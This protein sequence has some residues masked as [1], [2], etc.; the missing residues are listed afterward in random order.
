MRLREF[1]GRKG[2]QRAGA[3]LHT[4]VETLE[5]SVGLIL[6]ALSHFAELSIRRLE[7]LGH[8]QAPAARFGTRG[9]QHE[10]IRSE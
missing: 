6:C 2:V 1:R 10:D 5:P 4:V 9:C 8:G 3:G 7:D